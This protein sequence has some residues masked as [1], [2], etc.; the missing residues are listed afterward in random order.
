MS[1]DIAISVKNLDKCYFIYDRPQDRLFQMLL[2]GRKKFY[3]E[4]WA[5]KDVS[6]DVRKGEIVGIIGEN[7]CGK[8]TLLQLVCGTLAS[9]RGELKTVGRTAA[10]LELG[11]GFNPEFSGRENVFLNGALFGFSEDE[12]KDRLAEITA[13]ADIGDFI[14]QPVKTYSSGMTVRLAFAVATHVEADILL[15][16][17]ALAVGDAAFQF[18]CLKHMENLRK[19]GITILFVSH[20]M[21]LVQSFCTRA[22]YLQ[23]GQVKADGHPEAVAAQYFFDTREQHRKALGLKNPL[24]QQ[25][26][27][28]SPPE[29]AAFGNGLGEIVNACFSGGLARQV[30]TPLGDDI[31]LEVELRC[32][33]DEDVALAVAVQNHRLVEVSG[34]RFPIEAD[35]RA[36]RRLHITLPGVFAPG[37]FFV[38]LRLVQQVTHIDYLPLQSQIA[39]LH[40]QVVDPQGRQNFL[41]LCRTDVTMEE[42][43][44]EPL[45][46][47][48]LLAVR[49]EELYID[50]CIRHLVEQ[51][52][53]VL[54]IDNDS[55]DSTASIAREWMGK[56]VI[57]VERYPYQGFYDWKGLLEFKAA[58]AE[59]VE[60]DW[61]IH[62]D[63]D[64]IRHS[65][66]TDET[67]AQAITRLDAQGY[68]AVN[69]DEY[70]F[71]P[72]DGEG[73]PVETINPGFDYVATFPLSY[74][75]AP[76]GQHRINAWKKNGHP[77]DLAGSGGHRVSFPNLRLA[78]ERLI[79]RHYPCLSRQ[80]LES[81]YGAERV[82]SKEEV[83]K[84]GWHGDRVGFKPERVVWPQP[85]TLLS[86][87]SGWPTDRI[88]TSHPFLGKE[89]EIL[90]P[91]PFIVGVGR[92]GTTLARLML[93]AHPDLTI[94][95]ETMFLAAALDSPPSTPDEFIAVVTGCHTWGDFHLSED[96]LR[97]ELNRLEA[98]SLPNAVRAF[99][100]LYARG[101]GKVR[102]GDKTPPYGQYVDRIADMLPEARFIHIIR[103]GR[104]VALSYQDKW[105]GPE[106]KSMSSLASFWEERINLTRRLA[107]SLPPER[108]M[109]VRFEDLV[110]RPRET[111]EL[112]CDFLCLP[113]DP[114]MLEYHKHAGDRL[115]EMQD[116]SSNGRQIAAREDLLR[117]HEKT[118]RPPDPGQIGKWREK[119]DAADVATFESV[120]AEL[121]DELGY[122]VVTEKE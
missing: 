86:K 67:L 100:S 89:T 8:S 73:T 50:R 102:W 109:E 120:A 71:L 12:M 19:K 6:F 24:Q 117:I 79:L 81:K 87:E 58:L 42:L 104:D 112:V 66:R 111:L 103:D 56:G 69:F 106:D 114:A 54:V 105:F 76:T 23:H 4:F 37:D 94:P 101:Q 25:T 93:D 41:G 75:F 15:I 36:H 20:D 59:T 13:F 35:G 92:S 97:E 26:P 31:H 44:P 61:F 40:F 77:V 21:S 17:E 11:I 90:R 33:P 39:A 47:V 28:G 10:L 84:L 121:L 119:M 34:K 98:F 7:G 96:A 113:F 5:L 2:R 85:E 29:A 110:M 14:D 70:V 80:H 52:I 32:P 22:V 51:G 30:Q 65:R 49:N 48:A 82:Y 55:T 107:A 108:Y 3:H 63:A 68:N 46:V 43:P 83:E 78:P 57:G 16:D 27:L 118:H 115:G 62:H 18:K 88:W 45:H 91:V 1:S 60:A 74:Y 99:Y 64:E 38:T 9:T 122:D 53:D 72:Q 95:A 116:H